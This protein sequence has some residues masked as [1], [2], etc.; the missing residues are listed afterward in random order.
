MF[1]KT[2]SCLYNADKY[3][4]LLHNLILTAFLPS[5][6]FKDELPLANQIINGKMKLFQT[7]R[8]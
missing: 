2:T 8:R 1:I 4:A 3:W 5:V 6:R 7:K